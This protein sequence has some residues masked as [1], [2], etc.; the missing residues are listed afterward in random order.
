MKSST[1]NLIRCAALFISVLAGL[2][3]PE[4][5]A[6]LPAA[7]TNQ[8]ILF[9][10][11]NQYQTDHH[12]TH[13]MFPSA[14]NELNNGY[15]E[16]GNSALKI[17]DPATGVVTTLL[18]AGYDGVVRDPDVHFSGTRVLFAWRKSRAGTYNIYEIN[19]DGTGLKQLTAHPDV[20]DIDPV[21]LADDRIVFVSGR[22]PKYVMCNRHLSHNLYR[23]DSDG[24]NITRIARSTLFEGHPALMADGRILYDRWEYVDR[25]FGDAQ[26]LWCCDPEGTEHTIYY[27][28]NTSSPGGMVDGRDIPGTQQVVCTFVACHDKPWGAIAVIDRRRAL[29]GLGAVVRRWPA[30]PDSWIK[31]NNYV[32]ADYDIFASTSPKYED[33][34]PLVDPDT[35]VGGR[36]FLCSKNIGPGEHMALSLLDA[37]DGSSTLLHDEG[38]GDVGCFS[39]MPLAARPRPHNVSIPRKYDETPGRFYVVDVYEGTHMQGVERGDVKYLRVVESPEKRFYTMPDWSGQGAEAPGVN[40]DSFETKRI[41]GTVPVEQDGSAYFEVPPDTFVFFQ[42]LDENKMM[43]Q[44]MRSGTLV[45]P[46][47]TQGCVGC[48]DNRVHAPIPV[49][50]AMPTAFTRAPNTLDGWQ[51]QPP[52]MFNY[53]SDVQPV[54][55]AKCM[56]CHDY[57]GPGTVKVTLAGDKGLCFNKSYSE[58]WKKGYTGAIGAGPAAIQQAKAW[59]SHASRLVKT[60]QSTHVNRAA[61]TAAEF[62]RIVTWLDLNAVYYPSYASNYPNNAAG[63][64]PLS[65]AQLS[66][67]AGYTGANV[68][69]ANAV[70][71]AGELV[72]FDRPEMSPCLAGVTGSNYDA[73]LAIIQAGQANLAALPRED[74]TN[75]VLMSAIDIWRENKYQKSLQRE[76][77]NRAAVVAGAKVYDG[78]PLIG[79]A[80][81]TALSVNEISAEVFGN[82]FY[83]VSN[84][85]ASVY[86]AWGMW[87]GGDTTNAWQYVDD[88]GL[89]G[90]GGFSVTL[91]ELTAGRPVYYRVFAANAEGIASA[92]AA[93]RFD[94]LSLL[95]QTPAQQTLTW[96]ASVT[97][98]AVDGAGSWVATA[99]N[100]V[101]TNG[102]HHFWSNHTGDSAAFG[103]GGTAGTVV[104]HEAGMT[105]GGL[106]FN[107]VSVGAYLLTGGSLTL[108]NAPVFAVH[109]PASIASE[110]TGADGFVKT[111]AATLTLCGENSYSGTTRINEGVIKLATTPDL[112][113]PSVLPDALLSTRVLHLD[114]SEP[115]T[116][117]AGSDG[118]GAVAFT[119]DPVGYW[120]DL[121]AS[122][123]PAK[124]SISGRRPVF[125]ASA[126]EFNGLPVLEFDGVDDDITSLLNINPANM[127]DMTLIM[128]Y[129]QLAKT[130]NGG[131]WGHDNG[132]WDRLQLLNFTTGGLPDGYPIATTGNRAPVNGMN[133]NAVLIYTTSLRNGV[134]NGSYVYING[135]SDGTAG[136]PAFTSTDSGGLSSLTLANISP[137]NAYCGKVQIGEV[138]VYDHALSQAERS[139][140]ESYLKNKWLASDGDTPIEARPVLPETG[141]AV[142]AAGAALDLGGLTQRVS[143]VS[144][145][146]VVSNG[147]L[148]VTDLIEP[149]GSEAVGSLTVPGGAMLDGATLRI[150]LARGASDALVCTGDL[151]VGG[152]TLELTNPGALVGRSGRY[153]VVVCSGTLTGSML[154]PE[155]ANGWQI[156]YNRTSGAGSVTI[157]KLSAGTRLI[158]Q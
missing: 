90:P 57:E 157:F 117:A 16:G 46:D 147:V 17:F 96:S 120:G 33:P 81:G 137:G 45:M 64:S 4:S 154:E 91:N 73:A 3:A 77:M 43:V 114:A 148:G 94:T 84:F 155:L 144:G 62:D 59:G 109:A 85:A 65:F 56:S 124:Q 146:G 118:S 31:V 149:G 101:D 95:G 110:L 88:A 14:A 54:F 53:L 40:W 108:T 102:V 66:Q 60:L 12:N 97:A 32:N 89:Q 135:V 36:Y 26:G 111:G 104:V 39:P 52:R 42:L 131:L 142:I 25:N 30:F 1:H 140:A 107:S 6:Q 139:N 72:A 153:T 87:D 20:D 51:G 67:L 10:V 15:Y 130:A 136:L 70:K 5:R 49:S 158:V 7:V 19:S 103:V 58:L 151:S 127:P 74:M 23:M 152:L 76:Q 29:D 125:V 48:H 68:G 116:L 75:C 112:A 132:G 156:Q 106:V 71:A 123:L 93:A 28:N 2:S 44:S 18:D 134:A 121:S 55:D 98:P 80:N 113:D 143:R 34:Y 8:P 115:A 100:W 50:A 145:S 37:K 79:V 133:T 83:T 128:V 11:R 122:N 35:G 61:L 105:V 129:R 69:S 9:A 82:L 99:D 41:L 63:R 27:G 150:D 92:Q 21:Y 78:Q 47:E 22:E 126:A 13:T 86:I 119:G 138:L 24:A 38:S 141:A